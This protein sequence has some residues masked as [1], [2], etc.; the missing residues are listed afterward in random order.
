MDR[1]EVRPSRV[2]EA[3]LQGDA[4]GLGYYA[5]DLAQALKLIG[6]LCDPKQEQKLRLIIRGRRKEP[7][8][9]K[10]TDWGGSLHE[11]Q[12]AIETGNIEAVSRY[13]VQAA[14]IIDRMAAALDPPPDSRHWRLEFVRKGQGRRSDPIRKKM[15]RDSAI[16][17]KLAL[18]TWRAGGHQKAGIA[19]LFKAEGISRATALRAKASR[20]KANRKAL[21][22]RER[23]GDKVRVVETRLNS[24]PR[25][26]SGTPSTAS[27]PAK[28]SGKKSRD[29]P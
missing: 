13:L 4:S 17:L 8:D 5:R 23:N 22:L 21:I 1:R 10:E 20:R 3:L 28:R 19:D 18:A 29:K 24:E 27:F 12:E 6:N 2:K 26:P 25:L 16:S 9:R 7:G 15:M 14:D 11:L